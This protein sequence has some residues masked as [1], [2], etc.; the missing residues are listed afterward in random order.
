M[1]EPLQLT[2]TVAGPDAERFAALVAQYMG[3]ASKPDTRPEFLTAEE[4]A[5]VLKCG[6][7]RIYE[8]ARTGRL[9]SRRDGRRVLF[10]RSDL[11]AYLSTPTQE[12]A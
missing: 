8:L 4:A 3:G 6:R 5:G 10:A 1:N 2:V 9:P 7:A 12:A 11:D